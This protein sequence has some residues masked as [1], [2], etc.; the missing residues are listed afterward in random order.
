M[1]Y[2]GYFLIFL[3]LYFI[4]SSI[5]FLIRIQG[6]YNKLHGI[7]VIECC[8]IPIVIIGLMFL[9]TN[10]FNV[11]KLIFF[12]LI[13]ITLNPVS[14]YAIANAFFKNHKRDVTQG[15]K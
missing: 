1:Q 7:S 15:E 14:T 10:I 11:I 9:Q 12:I 4:I 5:I 6:F 13:I 2:L 3:G 8:G